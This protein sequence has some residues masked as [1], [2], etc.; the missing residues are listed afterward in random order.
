VAQPEFN[1]GDL[2]E[3]SACAALILVQAQNKA[4]DNENR[5][6]AV[7]IPVLSAPRPG[8]VCDYTVAGEMCQTRA[9][10][11]QI[12]ENKSD[13]NRQL[14]KNHRSPYFARNRPIDLWRKKFTRL[15]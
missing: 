6:A 4:A 13:I 12:I 2:F 1:T 7:H 15:P 9:Q 8:P 11:E 5:I 14:R 3:K 10:K